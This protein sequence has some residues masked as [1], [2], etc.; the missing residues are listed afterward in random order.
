M[1]G[2]KYKGGSKLR[3]VY[4]SLIT[5]KGLANCSGTEDGNKGGDSQPVAYELDEACGK[6]TCWQL[7]LMHLS[8][9]DVGPQRVNER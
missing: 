2:R 9:N 4:V 5:L 7:W 3:A 8:C 1:Q 6:E